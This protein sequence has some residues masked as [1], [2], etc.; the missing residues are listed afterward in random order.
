MY[1]NVNDLVLY[2][3]EIVNHER[4]SNSRIIIAANEALNIHA[5]ILYTYIIH[6][7]NNYG[8]SNH[9]GFSAFRI[10]ALF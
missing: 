2:R 8:I 5:T 9:L 1:Y 3:Y 10:A 7:D 6:I 4:A